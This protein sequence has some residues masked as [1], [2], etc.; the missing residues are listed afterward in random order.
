MY[1]FIKLLFVLALI[2]GA[3]YGTSYVGARATSG[4]FLG[5]RPPDL[6][7]RKVQF[8]FEGVKNLPGNPRVWIVS[9]GP[10]EIAGASTIRFYISPGGELL[11][12]YPP[13]LEERLK[14]YQQQFP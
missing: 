3:I 7:A 4:K 1:R 13:D 14:P 5:P 6:G 10:T 8:A 11:R 12:T 2:G 9:Y